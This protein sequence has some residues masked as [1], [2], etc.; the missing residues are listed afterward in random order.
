MISTQQPLFLRFLPDGVCCRRQHLQSCL[1]LALGALGLLAQRIV[2]QLWTPVILSVQLEDAVKITT[3]KE[4]T[5][6]KTVIAVNAHFNMGSGN[7]S[8]APVTLV[9]IEKL[10]AIVK[11][12]TV[13]K[14]SYV[15]P[16][17]I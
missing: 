2:R 12:S 4:F 7:F 3:V 15:I 5:N 14:S 1:K 17:P 8:S 16:R 10:L 11:W 9:V 6:K 13:I